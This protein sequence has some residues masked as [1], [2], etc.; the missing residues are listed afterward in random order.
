MIPTKA[1]G[2]HEM[3]FTYNISTH[4]STMVYVVYKEKLLCGVNTELMTMSIWLVTVSCENCTICVSTIK[5]NFTLLNESEEESYV[6]NTLFYFTHGMHEININI[7]FVIAFAFFCNVNGPKQCK[8]L[9]WSC[10]DSSK[11][12]CEF[13]VLLCTALFTEPE[14]YFFLHDWHI[15]CAFLWPVGPYHHNYYILESSEI[16]QYWERF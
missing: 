6:T 13:L 11:E 9:L 7:T 5:A 8:L 10:W 3:N 1:C 12:P 14:I 16:R 15:R 2:W 4:E